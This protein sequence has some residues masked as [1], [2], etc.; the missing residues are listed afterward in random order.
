ML[1]DARILPQNETIETEVCIVGAGPAG[2]TLARELAGADFR[3]CLLESGGLEFD[4]DTQ[5]LAQGESANHLFDNLTSQRCLQFGGTAN[6]WKISIGKNEIGVRYAPLDK[7]DFEKR[8]W[9][10]YS[11]WPFDKSHLDPFYERA[12]AVCK[13]GNFAYDAAT[14]VDAKTPPL[15]LSN[16]VTTTMFQFGPRAVFTQESREVINQ[17][18]NI[19]TYLNANLIEIETDAIGKNVTRLRV[20]CLSGKE[21]WVSAKI[22]ILAT[23]GIEAARLLLLS[24]KSQKKGLGNQYDLVGRFFMDHS[25]VHCGNLIPTNAEIFQQTALYDLRRV[26]NIPVM[27]KLALSEDVMHREKL[28]NI[29][30]LLLPIPKPYQLKAVNSL[31]TLISS[32]YDPQVQENIFQHLGNVVMGLDYILP[33]AYGAMTKQ[34]PLIPV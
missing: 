3:V 4:K 24:N 17:A 25:L 7:I 18:R 26:N 6:Y 10:P 14:W 20:A 9:L 31:K 15:P 28:L 16:N 30:T 5:S 33:A 12:Q 32:M 34:L 1:I 8:D 13:L 21:F 19:T 22:V 29:S 27:G 2:I 23:G 11:G